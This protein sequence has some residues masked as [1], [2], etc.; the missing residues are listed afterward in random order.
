MKA[1]DIIG[2]ILAE[3]KVKARRSKAELIKER[4]QIKKLAAECK[5]KAEKAKQAKEAADTLAAEHFW[6]LLAVLWNLSRCG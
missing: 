5:E 6:N 2:T 3:D 1:G 4:S